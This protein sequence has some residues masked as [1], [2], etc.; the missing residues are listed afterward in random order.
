MVLSCG[1]NLLTARVA[2]WD[3]LLLRSLPCSNDTP[4]IPR[5]DDL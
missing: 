2:S 5:I 3:G 1:N 4:V